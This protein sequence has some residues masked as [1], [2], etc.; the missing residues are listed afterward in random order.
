MKKFEK[1]NL[2]VIINKMMEINWY[3]ERYEDLIG[4]EDWVIKF[5]TTEKKEEEFREYLR[6]YLK[7]FVIKNR[8]EKEIWRFILNRWLRTIVD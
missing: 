1:E 2:K 3:K 7:P 5:T 6:K 8:L 4:M